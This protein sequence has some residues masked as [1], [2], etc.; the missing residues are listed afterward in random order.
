MY[1]L[2]EPPMQTYDRAVALKTFQT[3]TLRKVAAWVE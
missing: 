2:K 1:L 3:E